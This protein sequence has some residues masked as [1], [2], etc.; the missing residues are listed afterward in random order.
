MTMITSGAAPVKLALAPLLH[1][2]EHNH[3]HCD[4]F[5]E[6]LSDND[7]EDDT[8]SSG[9]TLNK[10]ERLKKEIVDGVRMRR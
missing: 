9:S 2:G 7:D 5:D 4:D 6:V 10:S 8:I 3:Y 1:P